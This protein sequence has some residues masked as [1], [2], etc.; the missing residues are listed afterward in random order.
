MAQENGVLKSE[1]GYYYIHRRSV[2]G[3]NLI[4]IQCLRKGDRPSPTIDGF[5]GLAY[6]NAFWLTK[7]KKYDES[8]IKIANDFV[9]NQHDGKWE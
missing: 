9:R 5:R 1:L 3:E 8:F 6:W 4:K 7:D 2:S